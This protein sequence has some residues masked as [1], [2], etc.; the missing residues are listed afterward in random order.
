LAGLIISSAI[1]LLFDGK[2]IRK[3]KARSRRKIGQG[4]SSGENGILQVWNLK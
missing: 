3:E 2:N 1:N 4:G